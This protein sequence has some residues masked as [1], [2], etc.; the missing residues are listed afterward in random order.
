MGATASGS[1]VERGA[2]NTTEVQGELTL[3]EYERIFRSL[4]RTPYYMTF[5]GGEPFLRK[6]LWEIVAL[7]C[8]ECRPH[9][10]TIPTNGILWRIIPGQVE[11][12]LQNCPET[13]LIINLSLDGVDE[14]HDA[15]RQVPGNYQL[16]LRTLAA[17]QELKAR[18]PRLVIGIHTV[19]SQYNVDKIPKIYAGLIALT[20]DS[21]IT[22][23][24]EER[25]ELDTVGLAIT[26]SPEAYAR[27]ADF[28]IARTAE[29]RQT[30][31]ARITQAFR[32]EYYRLVKRILREKR[33]VIP[34]YAG[35]A[36]CHIA[37]DGDV[38]TCCIRAEPIGNLREQNYDFPA[39]WQTRQ[40]ARLRA[41][42]AAGECA[43]PMANASYTNM[44]LH[45]PTVVRV[46][47]RWLAA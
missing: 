15:I 46:L 3:A 30:G 32:V 25:H 1:L 47:V 5:S 31:F 7:A 45:V 24:A 8:R 44:L 12:I 13:D 21:Y 34:C 43:C 9:V 41:S 39:V 19:I 10:I 28:L 35:W 2:G 33:Q 22:E 27:A 6:D 29:R 16:A 20:P 11:K 36:S 18:Y 26:P 17:L 40:A 23:V 42:I 4:G 37:P 38:W 14:D